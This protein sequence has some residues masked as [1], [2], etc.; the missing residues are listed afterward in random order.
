MINR[1]IQK[2]INGYKL[3]QNEAV[4]IQEKLMCERIISALNK[5]LYL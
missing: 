2:V 4:S 1:D 5:K 3:R